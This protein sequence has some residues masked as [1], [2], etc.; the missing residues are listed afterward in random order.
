MNGWIPNATTTYEQALI[1]GVIYEHKD[2]RQFRL[3]PPLV[4]YMGYIP[5]EEEASEFIERQLTE[6]SGVR[7]LAH[8]LNEAISEARQ[9]PHNFNPLDNPQLRSPQYGA[10]RSQ[11]A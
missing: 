1:K 5:S 7:E 3:H 2:G 9:K 6:I 11:R 10:R 8:Q 4:R